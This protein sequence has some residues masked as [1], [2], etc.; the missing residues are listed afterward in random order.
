MPRR[1]EGPGQAIGALAAVLAVPPSL[2]RAWAG[3]LPAAS[4]E[5]IMVAVSRTNGCRGC[6]TVHRA[7]AARAGVDE[8]GL[9]A[10]GL[11]DGITLDPAARSAIAYATG[12]SGSVRRPDGSRLSPHPRHRPV[13]ARPRASRWRTWLCAEAG[14]GILTLLHIFGWY[15]KRR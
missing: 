15:E 11:G 4:R 2:A 5:A 1:F 14:P 10:I 3:G 7:G 9:K 8:I 6:T 12:R 13:P